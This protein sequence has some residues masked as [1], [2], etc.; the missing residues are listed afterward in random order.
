MSS[1]K[2]IVAAVAAV[3]LGGVAA[4]AAPTPYIGI[5]FSGNPTVNLAAGES[6][7]F[8]A[9]TNYNNI[10]RASA[11]FT[12]GVLNNA[13]GVAT[14]V[15]ATVVSIEQWNV[16]DNAVLT[17]TSDQKLLRGVIVGNSAVNSAS[18]TLNNVAAGQ[19]T[20]YLYSAGDGNTNGSREKLSLTTPVGVA[21]Y[22]L[23]PSKLLEFGTSGYVKAT[24]TI[25]PAGSV[26]Y[27]VAN[28]ATWDVTLASA[29]SITVQ[30]Y[31][32]QPYGTGGFSDRSRISGIQLMQVVPEPTMLGLGLVGAAGLLRRQRKI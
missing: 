4:Q 12:T 30:A 24:T 3:L 26:D 14:A 2:R 31:A 21:D 20:I 13:S 7:G 11:N 25:Q 27:P 18:V 23:R 5:N 29:G 28:Y 10:D 19:Y 17:P 8:I 9:Q 1:S 16:D 15:T 22:Y 32:G 6:A